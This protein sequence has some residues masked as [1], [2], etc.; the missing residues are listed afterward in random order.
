MT[1]LLPWPWSRLL[2]AFLY[3]VSKPSELLVKK[4][5]FSDVSVYLSVNYSI[6]W[7]VHIY[8]RRTVGPSTE[9]PSFENYECFVIDVYSL[10]TSSCK[11]AWTQGLGVN[12]FVFLTL[13]WRIK[14]NF[15]IIML[16]YEHNAWRTG[17]DLSYL[18]SMNSRNR[19][20]KSGVLHPL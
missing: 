11:W 12:K 6:N 19:S 9:R 3:M 20:N 15:T 14:T 7:S 4:V 1:T 10:A 2:T 5:M 17:T 13:A 16:M 8:H 18:N